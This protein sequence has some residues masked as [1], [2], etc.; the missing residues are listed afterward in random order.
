MRWVA[1]LVALC[2]TMAWLHHLTAVS[3]LEARAGLALSFLLVGA[4]LAGELAARARL[5]RLIGFLL[6]GLCVGPAWLDLIRADELDSLSFV[7][8]AAAAVIGFAAGQLSF[9]TLRAERWSSLRLAG[10]ALAFP[11]LAVTALVL[12]VAPWFPLPFHQ[13]ARNAVGVALTLGVCAAA[14]SPVL[15]SSVSEELGAPGALAARVLRVAVLNS[16]GALGLFALV[17]VTARALGT[18]GTVDGGV[19][20]AFV[21]HALGALGGGAA[22][23]LLATRYA[24]A[25]TRDPGL[26]LLGLALVAAAGDAGLGLDATLVGLGAG[27]VATNVGGKGAAALRVAGARASLPVQAVLFALTGAALRVGALAETWPWVVLLASVRVVALRYG[28]MWA[29]RVASVS[30]SA[31]KRGWLGLVPQ[32][33]ITLVLAAA[34]RRAFPAWG[35]SLE[36]LVAGTVVVNEL[37]GPLCLRWM[38]EHAGDGGEGPEAPDVMPASAAA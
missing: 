18:P 19:A 17:L 26:V 30:A 22:L 12:S 31:A 24:R 13:S 23:G 36:T 20:P 2:L 29:G 11:A 27:V 21:A 8:H 6:L 28:T 33:G 14:P 25:M 16:I 35:V 34:A 32:S 3:A 9:G 37:G 1:S 10:G 7:T 5:P 15:V 4:W 38:L